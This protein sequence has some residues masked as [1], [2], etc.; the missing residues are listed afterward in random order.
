VQ[1]ST[2]GPCVA[3]VRLCSTFVVVA[4]LHSAYRCL[5]ALLFV[6]SLPTC[7]WDLH[8]VSC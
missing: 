3:V 6:V 4:K 1:V 2:D 5:C 7:C 8:S